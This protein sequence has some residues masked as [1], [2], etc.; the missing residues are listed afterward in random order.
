MSTSELDLPSKIRMMIE[1]ELQDGESLVWYG[2]PMP[3]LRLVRQSPNLLLQIVFGLLFAAFI[4]PLLCAALRDLLDAR[5]VG[6]GLVL[7]LFCSPFVLA[8][9]LTI[10]SPYWLYRQARAT[11]YLLTN[12]RAIIVGSGYWGDPKTIMSLEPIH[13][14]GALMRPHAAGAGD[15]LFP[16]VQL[17][18]IDDFPEAIGFFAVADATKVEALVEALVRRLCVGHD[19]NP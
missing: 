10:G 8:C 11:A 6:Q 1:A 18:S 15:L 19:L 3:Q 13:L 7:V 4:V 16:Q 2:Q 5:D 12:R 17:Q 9:V 14:R